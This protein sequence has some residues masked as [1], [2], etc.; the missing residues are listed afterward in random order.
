MDIAFIDTETGGLDPMRHALIEIGAFVIDSESLRERRRFHRLVRPQPD[1]IVESQAAEINGYDPERWA[2]GSAEPIQALQE[3]RAFMIEGPAP[4]WAGSNP[5][6]DRA[7]IRHTLAR[8]DLPEPELASH[9]SLDVGSL[10]WPLVLSGAVESVS[11]RKLAA[12][13]GL[14]QQ[15][16]TALADALQCAEIYRRR[17][18]E[19]GARA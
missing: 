15:E 7:F 9:H 12:H 1:R 6:F 13:Y 2:S 4:I 10:C 14:G 19:I 11:Q 18:R 17:M 5:E 3:F 16:H 8:L